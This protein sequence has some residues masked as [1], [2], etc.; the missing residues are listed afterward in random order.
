MSLKQV[1]AEQ[2]VLG[3]T[4]GKVRL[5]H[6]YVIDAFADVDATAEQILIDVRNGMRVEIKPIS[7]AKMRLKRE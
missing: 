4:A 7:P 2:R 3:H 1:V 6:V 5:E